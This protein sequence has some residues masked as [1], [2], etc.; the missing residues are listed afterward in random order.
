MPTIDPYNIPRVSAT[1]LVPD[2]AA[3]PFKDLEVGTVFTVPTGAVYLKTN[4]LAASS[5]CPALNAVRLSRLGSTFPAYTMVDVAAPASTTPL[6][7]L[8]P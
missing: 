2:P 1:K 5:H 4:R 7:K 8:D 6:F 3:I